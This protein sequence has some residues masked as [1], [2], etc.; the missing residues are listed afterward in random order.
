MMAVLADVCFL[1][2]LLEDA[3]IVK[4]GNCP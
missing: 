2:S 1:Q 4:C 3:S